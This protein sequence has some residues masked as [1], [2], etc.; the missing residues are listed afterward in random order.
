MRDS[1]LFDLLQHC[2]W[3]DAALW[4]AVHTADET[5]DA[6]TDDKIVGWLHHIHLV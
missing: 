1:Q 5:D 4:K 3:A 2:E 6:R